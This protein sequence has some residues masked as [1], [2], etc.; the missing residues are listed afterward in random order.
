[1]KFRYSNESQVLNFG[2]NLFDRSIGEVHLY[3]IEGTCNNIRG[4]IDGLNIILRLGDTSL[5]KQYRNVVEQKIKYL[6][7]LKDDPNDELRYL[8]SLK[9]ID[10]INI[11]EDFQIRF[12]QVL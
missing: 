1:M 7:E 8:N 2:K 10:S 4:V 6:K 11:L 5:K 3:E 9:R 12:N